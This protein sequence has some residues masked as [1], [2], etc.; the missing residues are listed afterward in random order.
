MILNT[1]A[2][3]ANTKA[4]NSIPNRILPRNLSTTIGGSQKPVSKGIKISNIGIRI[5]KWY[6]QNKSKNYFVVIVNFNTSRIWN[7][8]NGPSS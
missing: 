3:P 5:D 6:Y 4:T 2:I 8:D 1:S 7:N